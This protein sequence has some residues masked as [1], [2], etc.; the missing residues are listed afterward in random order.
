MTQFPVYEEEETCYYNY[1]CAIALPGYVPYVHVSCFAIL[2]RV[3]QGMF[4]YPQSF[5]QHLE[6]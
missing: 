3:Y 2:I 1:Q 6:Q 5:K 4:L